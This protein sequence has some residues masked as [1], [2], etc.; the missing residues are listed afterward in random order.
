[1]A[2]MMSHIPETAAAPTITQAASVGLIACLATY[3]MYMHGMK[4]GSGT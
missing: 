1:M 4:E 2:D 3:T